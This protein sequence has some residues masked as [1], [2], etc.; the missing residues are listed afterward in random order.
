MKHENGPPLLL[1]IARILLELN[2][3]DD[4]IWVYFD[5]QHD[6]ILTRLKSTYEICTA[7]VNGKSH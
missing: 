5:S 2:T 1:I 4:P 6:H 3:S 7:K